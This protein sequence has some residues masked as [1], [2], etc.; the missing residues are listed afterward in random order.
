[1]VNSMASIA[2]SSPA[3]FPD[4]SSPAA[5]MAS[6][7]NAAPSSSHNQDHV[8]PGFSFSS[9]LMPLSLK[10]DRNNYAYWR[11][12]VLPVVRAHGLEGFLL[13]NISCPAQFMNST[14]VSVTGIITPYNG[15]R[16]YLDAKLSK[17]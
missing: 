4:L 2:T 17:Q 8:V 6:S 15:D 14:T 7:S 5:F 11:S 16:F 1:M 12:Q 10:L 13:G 3:V 9:S